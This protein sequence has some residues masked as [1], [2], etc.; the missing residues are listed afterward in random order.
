MLENHGFAVDVVTSDGATWNRSMWKLFGLQDTDASCVYPCYATVEESE[1]DDTNAR[2][3]WFCSDV[4][5]L[6]KNLRNFLV[7]N[8]KTKVSPRHFLTELAYQNHLD[9]ASLELTWIVVEL[10]V[11][12]KE[13]IVKRERES[14]NEGENLRYTM[15]SL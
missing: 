6:V 10:K 9:F 8:G 2:R 4:L 1:N 15:S 13:S 3:L 14:G 12:D 5:H 11:D 7:K